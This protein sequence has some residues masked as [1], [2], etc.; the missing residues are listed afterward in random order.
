[1]EIEKF[2]G[3]HVTGE[4]LP[5]DQWGTEDVPMITRA[6]RT[7]AHGYVTYTLDE[8]GWWVICASAEKGTVSAGGED[9][10]RV[11]RGCLW[12]HVEEKLTIGR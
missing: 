3:F 12:L 8:P 5:T 1:M 6:A 7:D 10:P 4:M 2:N 9:Y 11:L